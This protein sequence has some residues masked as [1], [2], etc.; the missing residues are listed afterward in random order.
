MIRAQ[1]VRNSLDRI[2]IG[3]N[4]PCE[5]G[6]LG[7]AGDFHDF[8]RGQARVDHTRYRGVPDVVKAKVL[9][10]GFIQNVRKP[11]QENNRFIYI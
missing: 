4:V 8:H 3:I 9:D 1:Y 7:M 5:S 6:P 2:F 10:A 11:I